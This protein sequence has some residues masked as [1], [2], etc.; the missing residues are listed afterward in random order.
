ME[1]WEVRVTS[2]RACSNIFDIPGYDQISNAHTPPYVAYPNNPLC[3]STK[4]TGACAVCLHI[5]RRAQLVHA[6]GC[7]PK[8][9]TGVGRRVWV[10]GR[11]SQR[12]VSALN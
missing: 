12:A 1:V 2:V 6:K 4:R 5:F 11:P 7:L 10:Q 3:C 8:H 9:V